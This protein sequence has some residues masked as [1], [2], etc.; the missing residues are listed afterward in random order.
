MKT[1]CFS[2][3]RLMEEK[4]K[5]YCKEARMDEDDVQTGACCIHDN[6]L[7]DLFSAVK[8]DQPIILKNLI[9]KVGRLEKELLSEYEKS[10]HLINAVNKLSRES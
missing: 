4:G 10:R 8:E 2:C 3:A 7:E 5:F 6:Y 1:V 9:A